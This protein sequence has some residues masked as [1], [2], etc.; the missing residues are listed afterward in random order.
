MLEDYGDNFNDSHGSG[1]DVVSK[2]AYESSMRQ[3]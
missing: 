2:F 3:C 1:L